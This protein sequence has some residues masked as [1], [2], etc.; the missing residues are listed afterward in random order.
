MRETCQR[1]EASLFVPICQDAISWKLTPIATTTSSAV[2]KLDELVR[3]ARIS[4]GD[5]HTSSLMSHI[6]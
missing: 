5:S 2:A 1:V 6:F 4:L 3:Y